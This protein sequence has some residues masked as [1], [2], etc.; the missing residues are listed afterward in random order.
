ME[1]VKIDAFHK[2]VL[3]F[4]ETHP[5][6]PV[7]VNWVW[8]GIKTSEWKDRSKVLYALRYLQHLGYLIEEPGGWR[9]TEKEL[10]DA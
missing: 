3:R 2:E 4:V 10:N 7:L 8:H 9:R 6:P 1:P 5:D